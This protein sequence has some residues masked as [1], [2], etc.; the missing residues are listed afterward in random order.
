MQTW[1]ELMDMAGKPPAEFR[2]QRRGDGLFD[3]AL[4][5]DGGYTCKQDAEQVAAL[6]A[7]EL[8]ANERSV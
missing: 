4:I 8:P 6:L 1:D 7:S 3:V 2:V 5:V